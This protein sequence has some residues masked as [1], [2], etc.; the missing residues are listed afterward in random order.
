MENNVQRVEPRHWRIQVA[1]AVL[2]VFLLGCWATQWYSRR[3][4]HVL[5]EELLDQAESVALTIN[6]E[7][8]RA[9]SFSA[10]DLERPQFQRISG[11]MRAYAENAGLH[12]I[13]SMA[14]K[15]GKIVFGPESL[16]EGHPEAGP[17]GTV[18]EQPDAIN[19]T[20]FENG[21]PV[22]FGPVRDE[23][24]RFISALAP[25]MDPASGKVMMVVG[26]D[27]KAD[28]WETAL[29][30]A[31]R[32]PMA[33][34]ALLLCVIF[35]GCALL[36]WR[37]RLGVERQWR[38]RHVESV[39]CLILGLLCTVAVTLAARQA[40]KWAIK[41]SFEDLSRAQSSGVNESM[42]NVQGRLHDLGRF[43]EG[44][45]RVNREEF[46]AFAAPLAR[47]GVAEV[48]G[49]V[50]EIGPGEAETLGELARESGLGELKLW[51]LNGENKEAPVTGE[52]TAH[53]VLF[54]EPTPKTRSFTGLDIGAEPLRRAAMEEARHTGMS[55]A[56]GPVP[57]LG[58]EGQP[59]GLIVFH[60]VT[61]GPQKGFV[62]AALRLDTLLQRSLR[63]SGA[64]ADVSAGLYLLDTEGPP[65]LLATWPENHPSA[66]SWAACGESPCMVVPVFIFGKTHALLFHPATLPPTPANYPGTWAAALAGLLLTALLTLYTATIS[67]HRARLAREVARQT[68]ALQ[69]SEARLRMAIEA[70]QQGIFDYN[71]Q[72]GKILVNEQ[73]A[74]MLGYEP[75]EF[76]ETTGALVERVHPEDLDAAMAAYKDYVAG[77]RP[78]LRI[79]CR[80]QAKSGEWKWIVSVG[81]LV[82]WD[83]EGR[84][85]RML[86]T[87]T[88]ITAIRALEEQLRQ[89][90]K[91]ESVGRLAG[92]V[93][94]DFNNMLQAILGYCD[95]A[96]DEAGEGGAV[97]ASLLEI[98][99]AAQRSAGL[100]KQLLTFARKQTTNPKLL[101]LNAAVPGTLGM[102]NRL[103]GENIDL[104]WRPGPDLWHVMIDPGQ[105][106]QLLTNLAVNARDAING[107]GSLF[108][109]T[110]NVDLA[111]KAGVSSGEFQPGPHV[112]LIVGDNGS[113]MGPD[114]LEHL[115][116]PFY[117]T[118][119]DGKGT[120]LGLA[121]VYGIVSQN[122]GCI[123]VRS[124]PGR[125]SVFMIY[126]PRAEGRVDSEPPVETSPVRGSET[127]LL[128]ED[129]TAILRLG[130][131]ILKRYGYQVLAAASPAEALGLLENHT[132][133]IHLL[134]TDVMMPGMNGTELAERVT[135]LRP[136]IR[137]L[138]ISGYTAEIIAKQGVLDDGVN[139]MQKPYSAGEFAARVRKVLDRA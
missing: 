66:H 88:D 131:S 56:A 80:Q 95:L 34:T 90:Q 96:L 83:A 92:G 73:Y 33:F 6:P 36:E 98:Q 139:F 16:G 130:A 82:E 114:V 120:G 127:V 26:V 134:A 62:A 135:A 128:V 28:A 136:E 44:S 71:L 61:A 30:R 3:A 31:K 105:L 123:A 104:V 79:E 122:R 117:T 9:L 37:G 18:Y 129:E 119:A 106:D 58:I 74:L 42:R 109:E 10:D 49:W 118:K 14:L 32:G 100:T 57:L 45:S 113:G 116:E 65:Q 97:R 13:Y 84:P 47:E 1:V 138:Y 52:G 70:A 76:Q 108:I 64:E 11:N 91:M 59:A 78:D 7:M 124:T 54:I 23:Y 46:H 121:T 8:V 35:L 29:R 125:G 48:W 12:S 25:V 17:P 39:F 41:E 55:S 69:E 19:F 27:M 21:T 15:D 67:G 5:R 126:L 85:L 99:S 51:R 111:V 93:A 133:P 101:D 68:A 89:S 50:Q 40:E 53:A 115:F 24:G 102:L 132:E 110:K 137:V 86:G 107:H 72:T 81:R 20:I 87:N 43:F 60:P 75:E 4:D 112:L 94:H 77:E 2:L 38:L 103:I 63:R 22:T